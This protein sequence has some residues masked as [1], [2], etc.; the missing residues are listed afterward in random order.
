M[1]FLAATHY[2]GSTDCD[3][4]PI[5]IR[6]T[7][8]AHPGWSSHFGFMN[9][10]QAAIPYAIH[11]LYFPRHYREINAFYSLNEGAFECNKTNLWECAFIPTTNCSLEGLVFNNNSYGD[12]LL[13]KSS[14]KYGRYCLI[15]KSRNSGTFCSEDEIY[16]YT[17][18]CGEDP[19]YSKHSRLF[20]EL[21]TKLF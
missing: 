12:E 7:G 20:K 8:M 17:A 11:T 6:S 18:D 19:K 1:K 14:Q 2:Q 16:N 10:L 21:W 3:N 15:Y 4:T 5:S 13:K 9:T